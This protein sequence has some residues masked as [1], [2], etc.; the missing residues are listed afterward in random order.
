LRN[1]QCYAA[2][3]RTSIP[4]EPVVK[5]SLQSDEF[6]DLPNWNAASTVLFPQRMNFDLTK[7]PICEGFRLAGKI[8]FNFGFMWEI[9]LKNMSG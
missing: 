8:G 3:Y 5:S 6:D 1:A 7:E 4:A 9:I 2:I